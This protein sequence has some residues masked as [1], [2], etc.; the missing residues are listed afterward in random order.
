MKRKG[1]KREDIVVRSE[2]EE[3]KG[4]EEKKE[5]GGKR[6][7]FTVPIYKMGYDQ[8]NPPILRD[9]PG[10]GMRYIGCTRRTRK[11]DAHRT[12]KYVLIILA[13]R[14]LYPP[15]PFHTSAFLTPPLYRETLCVSP[16]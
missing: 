3:L 10:K 13:C 2:R 9:T 1:R 4:E 16:P 8:L 14:A 5:G 7:I 11:T 12:L 6:D 15:N